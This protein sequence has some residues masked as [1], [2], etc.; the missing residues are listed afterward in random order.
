MPT[1]QT[2]FA[3]LDV[4]AVFA[5]Y[6]CDVRTRLLQLRRLILDTADATAGVGKLEETLRW[7]EPS[8]L[9]TAS[10]SGSMVRIHWKPV[11]GAHCRMYFHCATNLVGTF[12]ALYPTELGYEGNRAILV[13]RRGAMPTNA[14]R[15][16][17]TLA[18]TYHS[19]R[20]AR[21]RA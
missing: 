16:C 6:P 7:S 21:N 15:H 4:E 18:L 3:N 10:R 5:N 19:A 13:P 12:R 14:H 17:F 11:D 20:K 9:T 1:Q 2:T 8:Y